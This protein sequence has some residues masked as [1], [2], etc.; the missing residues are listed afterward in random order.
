VNA[1][2]LTAA[3]GIEYTGSTLYGYSPDPDF[4]QSTVI[5]ATLNGAVGGTTAWS[6]LGGRGADSILGD[7]NGDYIVGDLQ[8]F[9]TNQDTIV[10]GNG[11][12]T[13]YGDYSNGSATD[14][15]ADSIVGGSS[16]D[17]IYGGAGGDTIIGNAGANEIYG[18]D[19]DDSIVSGTNN[20]TVYGG[21]GNDT[22]VGSAGN[23]SLFGDAG[24]NLFQF[25][26]G[27]LTSSATVDGGGSVD[28]QDTLSFTDATTVI[29]TAFTNVSQIQVI[30]TT[31][32]TN[33]SLTFGSEASTI[34]LDSVVG[35]SGN[36]TFVLESTFTDT[37]VTL[38]G[39][40]GSDSIS[41]NTYS[42]ITSNYIDAEG[43]GGDTDVLQIV[44]SL[45]SSTGPSFDSINTNNV[46]GIERLELGVTANNYVA[47]SNGSGGWGI[48]TVVGGATVQNEI[49]AFGLT[50]QVTLLGGS[51][52]DVLTGGTVADRL[53]GWLYTTAAST[54]TVADT[55]T[56]GTGADTFVLGD[57]ASNAYSTAFAAN[58]QG[59][60]YGVGTDVLELWGQ[61]LLPG[62]TGITDNGSNQVIVDIGGTNAYTINYN[63]LAG[64]GDIRDAANAI[65]Y[66]SFT[67][68]GNMAN[69]LVAAN[70]SFV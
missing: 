11:N 56:G 46:N 24:T 44:T 14:G 1:G 35:G 10:G 38:R 40:T 32:A 37:G 19:G 23:D 39:G 63:D 2:A 30:T 7:N 26:N 20:D 12:N 36:D 61:G 5:N 47:L 50:A 28:G 9:A 52:S 34:G 18:Q 57:T 51:S 31:D 45:G 53:Q 49:S 59:F 55:F 41:V 64:T 17:T 48:N 6:L 33:N 68:N 16:G 54:N 70:F 66:G 29:D 60:E 8:P 67:Y 62:A 22:I 27:I 3:F 58:I 21:A 13:I 65:T 4:V 43:G 15:S 42:Q 25:A 69:N